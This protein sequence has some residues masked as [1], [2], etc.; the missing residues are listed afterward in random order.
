MKVRYIHS[1]CAVIETNDIILCS[2]PWFTPGA[3]YGSWHQ[4]PPLQMDPIDVIGKVDAIYVSHIHPDHYDIRFLERY[5]DR[6]H[7]TQIIIGET[8]RS[9]LMRKMRDDGL[10]PVV[11]NQARFGGTTLQIFA[12][13]A[14]EIDVEDTAMIVSSE[15][16]SVVNLNDNPF[17]QEQV[18]N[19]LSVCP[20]GRPTFAL[21]PYCGAG[22]YPQTF[23]F[24]TKEELEAA[25]RRKKQQF[26]GLYSRYVSALK[27]VKS[28]PFAG[29]YFLGGPL[30]GLNDCRGVADA[31]EVLADH[32]DESL[33][34]A[35]GGEAFIDIDTLEASATRSAP[36]D[37]QIVQQCLRK[38]PFEGYDYEKEIRPID[39]SPPT[40]LPLV[41]NAYAQ[42][43]KSTLVKERSWVCIKPNEW[44][45]YMV[46][47]AFQDSQVS[48]LEDVSHLQPRCEIFIDPRLLFGLLTGN[49]HWNSADIGSHYRFKR[50]PDEF[51]RE[52][53]A[54]LWRL[55]V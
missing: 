11:L 55:R 40:L 26:L 20:L 15:T 54:F 4:Y 52:V 51:K 18:D 17:D 9:H 21:L 23:G 29:N 22:P 28:M 5:L 24:E 44:N 8:K 25:A 14:H 48:V 53:H 43:I 49:Y 19:I 34:L 35:D 33:V 41:Q 46:F 2:D 39:G 36:Y 45:T 50:V 10:N 38:M 13:G 47:D 31:T 30:A 16:L 37:D 42:A 6:Y 12:N 7:D 1:A 27:P 32:E 3:Y